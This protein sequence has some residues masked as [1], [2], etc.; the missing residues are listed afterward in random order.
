MVTTTVAPERRVALIT[1][2]I[3][4]QTLVVL[5][6]V[7]TT[8][9]TVKYKD[10]VVKKHKAEAPKDR[11]DTIFDGYENLIKQQ[12][13]DILRKQQQLEVTQSIIER[14]QD[15]IDQTREIVKLQK[16]ELE[17]YKETNRK[18]ISQLETMKETHNITVEP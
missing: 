18:L 10:R 5:G 17:E 7:L 3:V 1:E 11:M 16:E 8:Y 6:S 9:L 4:I 12:Q 15:E 14:L 13:E 2:N